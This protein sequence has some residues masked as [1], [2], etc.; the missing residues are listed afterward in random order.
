MKRAL[1]LAGAAFGVVGLCSCGLQGRPERPVPLWGNPP[2]EGP[3]DPR[4]LK[5]EKDRSDA[6]KAKKKADQAA[7]RAKR[8]SDAAATTP[9]PSTTTPAPQ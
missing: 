1:L 7:E 4:T 2:S 5:A 8:A 3:D 6:D 9:A